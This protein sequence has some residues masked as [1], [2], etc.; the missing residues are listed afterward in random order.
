MLFSSAF[1]KSQDITSLQTFKI[2]HC[3][4]LRLETDEELLAKAECVYTDQLLK[5]KEHTLDSA[6]FGATI[7]NPVCSICFQRV[8]ECPGHF[9]VIQLPFPIPQAI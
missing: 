5:S 8:E 1:N 2:N 6:L 7:M 9:S 4:Q 3:Y